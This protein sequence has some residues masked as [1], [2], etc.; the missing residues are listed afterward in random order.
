[1]SLL[2]RIA[3][4]L[5]PPAREEAENHVAPAQLHPDQAGVHNDS[6]LDSLRKGDLA[7][8]EESFRLALA[9]STDLPGAKAILP[10]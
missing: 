2:R 6:G 3:S 5:L 1:M 10:K 9:L 7:S 4:L 8:A